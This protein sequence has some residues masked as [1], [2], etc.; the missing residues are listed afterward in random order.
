MRLSMLRLGTAQAR[1]L[2]RCNRDV[3]RYVVELDH[4]VNPRQSTASHRV[5]IT[6]RTLQ[7]IPDDTPRAAQPGSTPT[8]PGTTPV[9]SGDPI[10]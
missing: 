2:E 9:S 6:G 10:A 8:A 7:L 5:A 1:H 3:T 4:E